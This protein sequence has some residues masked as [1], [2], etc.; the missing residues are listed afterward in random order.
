MKT[1]ATDITYQCFLQL[2]STLFLEA[3]LQWG[4][5]RVFYAGWPVIPQDPPVCILALGP[6]LLDGAA[7]PSFVVG[8]EDCI[9]VLTFA[10]QALCPLSHPPSHPLSLLL[11]L[12]LTEQL[13]GSLL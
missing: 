6:G 2:L 5:H 4:A 8:A 13:V 12:P 11:M 10:G 9:Q 1:V 7:T 3:A